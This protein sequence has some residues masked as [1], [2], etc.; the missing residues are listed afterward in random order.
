ME[1][2]LNGNK[3]IGYTN[4]ERINSY[5]NTKNTPPTLEIAGESRPIY[6]VPEGDNLPEIEE[7]SFLL[8][9][10]I[11]YNNDPHLYKSKKKVPTSDTLLDYVIERISHKLMSREDGYLDWEGKSAETFTLNLGQ[12]GHLIIN[13]INPEVSYLT[14]PYMYSFKAATTLLDTARAVTEAILTDELV[15]EKWVTSTKE[16]ANKTPIDKRYSGNCSVSDFIDQLPYGTFIDPYLVGHS[17]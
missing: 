11:F 5:V 8:I 16:R 17:K 6:F 1:L 4:A 13:L 15:L 2:W 12:G 9:G 10:D 7:G 3:H 14:Y